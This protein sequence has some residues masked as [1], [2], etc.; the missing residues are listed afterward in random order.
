MDR[1][2]LV[3]NVNPDQALQKV[4]DKGLQY[5]PLIQDS[6]VQNLTKLLANMKLKILSWNIANTLIFFAGKM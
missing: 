5:L 2:A 3:N 6:F 4:T 1:Q